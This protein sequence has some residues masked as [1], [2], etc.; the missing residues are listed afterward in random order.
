MVVHVNNPTSFWCRYADHERDM[1]KID[2]AVEQVVM[3]GHAHKV[4]GKDDLRVNCIYLAPFTDEDGC[5][6]YYRARL[7]GLVVDGYSCGWDLSNLL[8]QLPGYLR[9]SSRP[10][11]RLR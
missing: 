10:L 2:E 8:C 1:D 9:P 6:D 4:K 3:N 11:H 7:D 5:T